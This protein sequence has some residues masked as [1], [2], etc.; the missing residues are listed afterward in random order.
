M[1][2]LTAILLILQL[3]PIELV[4]SWPAGTTLDHADLR[5]T[6]VVWREIVDGARRTL[7]FAEFYASDEDRPTHLGS[8]IAAIERSTA[9]GVRVRF[10]ADAK[11]QKTYA[12]TLARLDSIEGVE[13]RVLDLSRAGLGG[14]L[15]AKYF[16]ADRQV[17]FVGSANFD[18]R[19][20]EHI[21]ELGLRIDLAEI[22]KV[23][24]A[25]FDHDW[26]LAG[27]KVQPP[28][29][30]ILGPAGLD[31]SFPLVLKSGSEVTRLIPV[32]SPKK[33]LP[34]ESL[35]DLP[36]LLR[37]IDGARKSVRVQ[38]LTYRPQSRSGETLEVDEALRR[39]ARR[40]V[41]VELLLADWCKRRGTIEALQELEPLEHLAV[42]LI[43]IP[44]AASG[45]IPYARVA[46]AKY[47]VADGANAWLGTSNWERDYFHE[48]RNA[49]LVIEGG[50]IPPR[51]DAFFSGNWTSPYA[52]PVDPK[53]RYEPPR[54]GE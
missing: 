9:R 31:T 43:T 12:A 8:V 20:L 47:L 38:L 13:V 36:H 18:W 50:S 15:H 45:H 4:E 11:F 54:I 1:G 44:P 41:Q 40:G 2:T 17:V 37:L 42:R 25:V 26:A 3:P 49:G 27:A 34:D 48:S 30:P 21:Q 14:V 32:F 28:S 53:A 39:A 51:L 7:E 23:F 35:W 19:S 6:P 16:I 52:Y 22:A 33:F 29:P 24:G 10:L 5:D 46:H